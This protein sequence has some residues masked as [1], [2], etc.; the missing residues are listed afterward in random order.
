VRRIGPFQERPCRAPYRL[1]LSDRIGARR[2][3]AQ[4]LEAEA[5]RAPGAGFIPP[6][7]LQRRHIT[8]SG[9]RAGRRSGT[10]PGSRKRPARSEQ[11]TRERVGEPGLD[12]AAGPS[13]FEQA[14]DG[15]EQTVEN[16]GGALYSEIGSQGIA[17][18]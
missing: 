17:G 7:A 5:T 4:V 12:V 3:T 6:G 10:R 18:G 13:P 15:V 14:R 1:G 2:P 9:N 11:E 16:V 8:D